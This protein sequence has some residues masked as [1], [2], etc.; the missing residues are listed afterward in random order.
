MGKNDIESHVLAWGQGGKGK[1]SWGGDLAQLC[2]GTFDS[3]KRMA[4]SCKCEGIM[5]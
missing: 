2:G 5:E 3:M 4:V 1:H